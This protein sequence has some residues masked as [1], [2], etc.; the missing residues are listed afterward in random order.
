[1]FHGE[2]G[3]GSWEL[4]VGSWE[5]GVG[6]WELSSQWLSE[7]RQDVKSWE[8]IQFCNRRNSRNRV[9]VKIP[10]RLALPQINPNEITK[11]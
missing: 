5:L 7:T 10:A 3:V 2:L 1:M 11:I 4:G 6:S 8:I 9:N